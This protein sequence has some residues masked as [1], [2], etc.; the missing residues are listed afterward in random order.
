MHAIQLICCGPSIFDNYAA[1][2]PKQIV[3]ISKL[4]LPGAHEFDRLMA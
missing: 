4:L 2:W 3:V 1:V